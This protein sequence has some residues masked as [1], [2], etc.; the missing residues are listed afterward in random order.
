[1][2]S[3]AL[4]DF[5]SKRAH[6][7][8]ESAGPP[9]ITAVVEL[10]TGHV[11]TGTLLCVGVSL[12]GASERRRLTFDFSIKVKHPTKDVLQYGWLNKHPNAAEPGFLNPWKK[13][14]FVFSMTTEGHLQMHYYRDDNTRVKLPAGWIKRTTELCEACLE[15]GEVSLK[16][17]YKH[18]R[19]VPRPPCQKCNGTKW[20]SSRVPAV[21]NVRAGPLCDDTFYDH[22]SYPLEKLQREHPAIDQY[23]NYATPK[24][25]CVFTGSNEITQVAVH[26]GRLRINPV[27]PE[28]G[29]LP[30]RL[31]GVTSCTLT[32][33][34]RVWE[35]QLY[36]HGSDRNRPDEWKK[37]F[38]ALAKKTPEM[39]WK[40]CLGL[41][42]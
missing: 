4:L 2:P 16:D 12:T 38:Y 19:I 21:L 40:A 6:W 8:Q 36:E 34:N 15:T 31:L 23:R 17:E 14:W 11:R 29:K 7:L 1:M 25:A 42:A 37:F 30:G 10:A 24:G 22:R 28:Y 9:A 26:E 20:V 39:S 3:S 13:R 35:F 41:E 33:R 5:R 18:F 27:T 32:T